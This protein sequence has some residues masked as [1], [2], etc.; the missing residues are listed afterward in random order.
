MGLS[1]ISP[2]ELLEVGAAPGLHIL[3]GPPQDQDETMDEEDQWR[4]LRD[5]ARHAVSRQKF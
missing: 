2:A 4:D 3:D 1:D 5:R